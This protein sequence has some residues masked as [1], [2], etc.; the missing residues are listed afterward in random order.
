MGEMSWAL[1]VDGHAGPAKLVEYEALLNEFFPGSASLAV[2]QYDRRRFAPEM[3][4]DVL[5]THPIAVLGDQ[6][7]PNLYYEPPAAV[8]GGASKAERVDWMIGQLRRAHAAEDAV[9]ASE[10]KLRRVAESGIVGLFYWD[11]HGGVTDAND[12]FLSML[13]HTRD[14]LA[15]GRVDWRALTPPAY[16]H[17]DDE[18]VRQLMTAGRHGPYEKAYL[19]ADGREVPV[20]IAS[21]FFDGSR[22]RGVCVC[23]DVSEQARA[24]AAADSARRLAED[25]SRAKSDFLAV[26][27]HEL[28]TPL[29]AVIGY[30]QLLSSGIGGPLTETQRRHLGRIRASA[31]HLLALIDEVLTLTRL[32]GGRDDVRREPVP[33]DR[34]LE[35]AAA[36]IEPLAGAKGLAFRVEAAPPACVLETDARKLRQVVVNLLSN[37]VK[38]TERGEVVL[39]ARAD[40]REVEISVRDTGIG[41]R[42]ELWERI[43]D[44]FWQ[45]EATW[46]RTAQGAGLGLHIARRLARLLG[47][48]VHVESAAGRGSTFTVRLPRGGGASAGGDDARADDAAPDDAAPARPG[49]G[50]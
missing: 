37:A 9:R 7:C 12:A 15:A 33:L 38:F 27:S 3:V 50:R 11:I 1:G 29:N 14:D 6:V 20:L 16:R 19:A 13:G 42:P 26:M 31:D 46:T 24:R 40:G 17:L 32:E 43:F 41:I 4:E 10:A 49:A 48:D 36:V 47:G 35:E 28:R 21:A 45:A 8:L 39:A 2:C 25:A 22:E 34:A 23:V 30:E 5:R 18:Y 44:P